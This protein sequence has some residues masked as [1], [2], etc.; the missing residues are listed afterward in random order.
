[1]S[2][3]KGS[4]HT[5]ETKRKISKTKR[6]HSVSMETRNKISATLNGRKPSKE[7]IKKMSEVKKGK[8][9]SARTKR[10]MSKAQKGRVVS[11]ETR[12]RMKKAWKGVPKGKEQVRKMREM[13]KGSRNPNWQNGIS[14]LPYPTDWVDSLKESIRE[15]DWYICQMCGVHQEELSKKLDVHHIDYD[16]EN[17]ALENLISLCRGC[18]MKTNYNRDEWQRYFNLIKDKEK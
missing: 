7:A 8:K 1:M 9:K 11:K 17:L 16:K 15:R 6:G 13:K 14:F 12:L 10:R 4:K 18:H 2:R 3:I 5:E